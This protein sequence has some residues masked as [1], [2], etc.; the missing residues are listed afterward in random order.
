MPRPKKR[1]YWTQET[2]DAIILY[3]KTD[4]MEIR[5][6]IF[7]NQIQKP[8]EK[9]VENVFNVFRFDYVD[10][11]PLNAMKETVTHCV[12]QLH[13]FKKEKGKSFGYFSTVAKYF[14]IQKNQKHLLS[15]KRNVE[16][17]AIMDDTDENNL[18]HYQNYLQFEDGDCKQQG[19][20]EYI[21]CMSQY[22]I[23]NV[24]TMTRADKNKEILYALIE[25]FN[26]AKNVEVHN[27]HGVH[28]L[29]R[30]IVG[31]LDDDD[32]ITRAVHLIRIK[33]K[34]FNKIYINYGELVTHDLSNEEQIQTIIFDE[35]PESI[36]VAEYPLKINNYTDD[37]LCKNPVI[38]YPV[39]DSCECGWKLNRKLPF[40]PFKLTWFCRG[41]KSKHITLYKVKE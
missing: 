35:I 30:E 1:F 15:N 41:C 37:T 32:Q 11:G 24:N 20:E 26:N 25:I 36:E 14:L 4:D 29:L 10:D 38:M 8:L 9:M 16:I 6:S 28:K 5:E 31:C 34:I 19:I 3:N 33:Q 40:F 23:E 21:K 7:I 18:H 17:T 12:Q 39:S 2:E 22:L 27:R 13:T